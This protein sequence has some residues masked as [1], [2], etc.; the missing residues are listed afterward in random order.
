MPLERMLL[1]RMLGCGLKTKSF[2]GEDM[3]KR[4]KYVTAVVV[5]G[6]VMA[7]AYYYPAETFMTFV[8]WISPGIPLI[9]I[10]I[11][12]YRLFKFKKGGQSV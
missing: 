9:L 3:D 11:L 10:V 7:I 5:A 2:S 6:V 12:V 1:M 8:L 4:I